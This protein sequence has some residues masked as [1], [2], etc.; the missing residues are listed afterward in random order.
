MHICS[1]KEFRVRYCLILN[2][3]NLYTAHM[4]K[5]FILCKENSCQVGIAAK[6]RV[7]QFSGEK[8]SNN[9]SRYSRNKPFF[10]NQHVNSKEALLTLCA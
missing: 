2:D 6:R 8:K 1:N 5:L 10:R 4:K 3:N 9:H 7:V